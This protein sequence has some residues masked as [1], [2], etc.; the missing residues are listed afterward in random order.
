MIESQAKFNEYYMAS[1]E[2]YASVCLQAFVKQHLPLEMSH[3]FYLFYSI[4]TKHL[5]KRFILYTILVYVSWIGNLMDKIVFKYKQFNQW[6]VT[7]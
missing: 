3:I 6:I 1:N 7:Q 5:I 4:W 2:V